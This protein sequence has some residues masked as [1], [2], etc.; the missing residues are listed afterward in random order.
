VIEAFRV[1]MVIFWARPLVLRRKVAQ[2]RKTGIGFITEKISRIMGACFTSAA[3]STTDYFPNGSRESNPSTDLH[4][5]DVH[6]RF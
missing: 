2:R 3:A 4:E 5:I 1:V 6:L